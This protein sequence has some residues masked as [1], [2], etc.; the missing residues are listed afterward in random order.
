MSNVF[1]I[2]GNQLH[3]TKIS[4]LILA[5]TKVGNREE[6]WLWQ[7]IKNGKGYGRLWLTV[8]DKGRYFAA[9]RLM[10]ALIYNTDPGD[11]LVCHGCDN[12]SCINP[13]HLFLGTARDNN[14]DAFKKGRNKTVGAHAKK[15]SNNHNSRYTEDIVKEIRRL[16]KQGW[17]EQQ[18]LKKFGGSRGGLYAIVNNLNWRHVL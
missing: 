9:H 2:N 15:G 16:H 8:N 1:Y 4:E 12:P 17:T 5:R 13:D 14:L 6:C 3:T 11:L 7:G 10:Y 18:L